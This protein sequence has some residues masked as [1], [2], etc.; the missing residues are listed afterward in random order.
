MTW[1]RFEQAWVCGASPAAAA[2]ERSRSGHR[3][4]AAARARVREAPQVF[5]YSVLF[6]R[7]RHAYSIDVV[8]AV[9]RILVRSFSGFTKPIKRPCETNLLTFPFPCR[10]RAAAPGP[11]EQLGRRQGPRAERPGRGE[12]AVGSGAG[13]ARL[14]RQLPAASSAGL[15]SRGPG[16]ARASERAADLRDPPAAPAGPAAGPASR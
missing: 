9:L 1:T 6:Y 16:T 7:R 13:P 5:I 11:A 2:A 10:H 12:R 4:Q 14:R 15:G 3:A 8:S